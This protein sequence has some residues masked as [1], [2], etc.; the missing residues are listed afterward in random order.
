MAH[1]FEKWAPQKFE[2]GGG[3]DACCES[4]LE[5]YAENVVLGRWGEIRQEALHSSSLAAPKSD[6]FTAKLF[7]FNT[8]KQEQRPTEQEGSEGM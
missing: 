2:N 6:G 3:L 5:N 7:I 8:D 1:H 4:V